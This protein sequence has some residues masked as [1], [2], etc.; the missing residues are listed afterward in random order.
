VEVA[1]AGLDMR[2][3]IEEALSNH[4]RVVQGTRQ[5]IYRA[6]EIGDQVTADLLTRLMGI[7]EKQEWFLREI[8]KGDDGM[9]RPAKKIE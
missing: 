1:A 9:I 5:A 8:L 7:H 4:A 6:D 3:M 2:G